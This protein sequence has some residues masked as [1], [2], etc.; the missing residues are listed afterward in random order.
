MYFPHILLGE[1]TITSQLRKTSEVLSLIFIEEEDGTLDN[2]LLEVRL[3]LLNTVKSKFWTKPWIMLMPRHVSTLPSVP[4]SL[5]YPQAQQHG[6]LDS[7]CLYLNIG[8]PPIYQ[9]GN[10]NSLSSQRLGLP[11]VKLRAEYLHLM[12]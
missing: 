3:S 4:E 7:D 8:P 9:L 2:V 12:G 6:T 5:L 11:S 10:S 1:N